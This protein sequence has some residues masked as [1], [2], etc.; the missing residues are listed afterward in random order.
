MVD[1]AELETIWDSHFGFRDDERI[2]DVSIDGEE[3]VIKGE[4]EE[5]KYVQGTYKLKNTEVLEE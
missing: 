5:G 1:T 3:I 2:T 4:N